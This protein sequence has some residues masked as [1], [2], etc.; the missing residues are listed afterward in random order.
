MRGP[1]LQAEMSALREPGSKYTD[2]M[3]E[4]AKVMVFCVLGLVSA[5]AAA[6]TRE[7]DFNPR[8]GAGVPIGLEFR[9]MGPVKLADY[10]GKRPMVL[11][12]GYFGCRNLCPLLVEGVSQALTGAGMKPDADYTAFFVSIDARDEQVRPKSRAGWHLLTG[13]ASAAQLAHSIGFTYYYDKDSGEFAHPTGFVVLTPEGHVSRYFS[14]VRFDSQLVKA[15]IAEAAQGRTESAFQRFLLKCF[16]D[17]VSGKY[18]QTV[19]LSV[20]IAAVLF[21]GIA[22]FIAWRYRASRR[23]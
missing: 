3:R 13:A 10:L 8:P 19:L 11:V 4:T 7:V 16:H 2:Q 23:R 21:L 14:G 5:G 17:P 9:E 6:H 12:L 15:A 18:S 1:Q 20:R 22:G